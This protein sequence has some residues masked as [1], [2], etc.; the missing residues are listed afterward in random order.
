MLFVSCVG[1]EYH[2]SMYNGWFSGVVT[3]VSGT[4][5]LCLYDS[6][7]GNHLTSPCR[8]GVWYSCIHQHTQNNNKMA[9]D[10]GLK[11]FLNFLARD[12]DRARM[13][14]QMKQI[15]KVTWRKREM[16]RHSWTTHLRHVFPFRLLQKTVLHELVY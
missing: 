7:L 14:I 3:L 8:V 9:T 5:N 4:G 13:L 12:N 11:S 1:V 6:Q 16:P 15:L 2:H 10:D